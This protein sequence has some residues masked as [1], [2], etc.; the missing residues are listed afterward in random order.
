MSMLISKSPLTFKT[1]NP[2]AHGL[3]APSAPSHVQ[4]GSLAASMKA[5]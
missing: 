4:L 5:R 2:E 1:G 3:R